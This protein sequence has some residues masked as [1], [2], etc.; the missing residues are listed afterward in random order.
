MNVPPPLT[1]KPTD[2]VFL[3]ADTPK[4]KTCQV[5][6]EN[7][8]GPWPVSTSKMKTFITTNLVDLFTGNNAF[9]QW[10]D[11]WTTGSPQAIA[12][13][14]VGNTGTYLDPLTDPTTV[15][16]QKEY[17][18]YT[19]VTGRTYALA[20]GDS[21]SSDTGGAVL[22]LLRNASCMVGSFIGNSNQENIGGWAWVVGS[23]DDVTDHLDCSVMEAPDECPTNQCKYR[24]A[25][26]QSGVFQNSNAWL[27]ALHGDSIAHT[28]FCNKVG[29]DP[30][31]NNQR[32][33]DCCLG[34]YKADANEERYCAP[35]WAPEDPI[36]ECQEV[37]VDQCAT[38]SNPSDPTSAS[39]MAV[40]GDPCNDWYLSS[41]GGTAAIR[42]DVDQAVEKFCTENPQ[43]V[44]CGCMIPSQQLAACAPNCIP[45]TKL[46]SPLPSDPGKVADV[47]GVGF[48]TQESGS[49][50]PVN[51][52]DPICLTPA[53][54]DAS[55]LKT[56]EVFSRLN[57]CPGQLCLQILDGNQYT[58]E[59]VTANGFFIN[60]ADMTCSLQPSIPQ[61]AAQPLVGLSNLVVPLPIT[62]EGVVYISSM[63]P[64]LIMN[65][66]P[67]DA[68]T[69]EFTIDASPPTGVTVVPPTSYSVS[70]QETLPLNLTLDPETFGTDPQSF[71]V[72]LTGTS[73]QTVLKTTVS[74]VPYIPE[75]T[76]DP[77]VPVPCKP[78]QS[79]CLS[80][81]PQA[82]VVVSMANYTSWLAMGF[83]WVI[84]I[85]IV[86]VWLVFQFVRRRRLDEF[87][88]MH[89]LETESIVQDG[90]SDDKFQNTNS[91]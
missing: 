76:F 34:K 2:P 81:E 25:P 18:Q 39:R 61:A 87:Q 91:Y 51:L 65:N 75:G 45:M 59:Q 30:G 78:D 33:I 84:V 74:L 73:D 53:C 47:R 57:S 32:V 54:S 40:T 80:P 49:V 15:Q 55:T 82:T 37:L 19:S 28:A 27:Q 67:S 5:C 11:S 14:C 60:N 70:P 36:G 50:I 13:P 9:D 85:V 24:S 31:V 16:I 63:P 58:A 89:L 62:S 26:Y 6:G 48:A 66:A 86:G 64:I 38:L 43:S 23:P 4:P 8:V 41:I 68:S 72:T 56:W 46:S 77:N 29:W 69:W 79:N 10:M 88:T 44:S 83:A 52:S 35:G 7:Y 42:Y 90:S 71:V 22:G 20:D 21:S 3:D 12:A 17:N 1:W